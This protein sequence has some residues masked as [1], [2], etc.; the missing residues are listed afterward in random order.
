MAS[1]RIEPYACPEPAT[2]GVPFYLGG[3]LWYTDDAG[4]ITRV[5][6]QVLNFSIYNAVT[7]MPITQGTAQGTVLSAIWDDSCYSRA[8]N[9]VINEAVYL[10]IQ[11]SYAGNGVVPPVPIQFANVRMQGTVQTCR[12]LHPMSVCQN[13]FVWDCIN[14]VWQ[15]T[16][17]PCGATCR[18]LHPV[19]VCDPTTQTYW[20]CLEDQWLDTGVPCS[21]PPPVQ[22]NVLLYI[23]GGVVVIGLVA[24]GLYL[25]TRKK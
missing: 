6:G 15:N 8:P 18:D 20:N 16:D 21:E 14:E 2:V 9:V 24:G 4:V 25:A 13:G 22:S 7:H 11:Y 12:D 3:Q 10:E 1:S 19:M 17:V 5:D 23:I